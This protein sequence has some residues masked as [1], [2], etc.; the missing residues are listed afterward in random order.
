MTSNER[1][2]LARIYV[3][4]QDVPA[5]P[6]VM[7]AVGMLDGLLGLPGTPERRAAF[8]AAHAAMKPA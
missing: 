1:A 8:A 2:T 6:G 3:E 4:L 5:S 7:A